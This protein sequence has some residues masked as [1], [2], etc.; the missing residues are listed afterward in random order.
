MSNIAYYQNQLYSKGITLDRLDMS[1]FYECTDEELQYIVDNPTKYMKKRPD[2]IFDSLRSL[3]Q[4]GVP[5]EF[6]IEELATYIDYSKIFKSY[7]FT[8]KDSLL[9]TK[10]IIN[11]DINLLEDIINRANREF[12]INDYDK[13]ISNYPLEEINDEY[14]LNETLLGAIIILQRL[15]N[16]NYKYIEYLKIFL[17]LFNKEF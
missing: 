7:E 15:P 13:T 16:S 12:I 17:D 8:K 11:E 1:D 9:V 14:L 4:M 6:T 2:E 3:K 10:F 5:D